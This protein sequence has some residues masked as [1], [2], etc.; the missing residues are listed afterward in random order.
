MIETDRLVL[1]RWRDA[2]TAPFFAMGQDAEVMRHIGPPMTYEDAA[3]TVARV[4]AQIDSDGHA[5]WAVECRAD[6]AFIGFCGV[7]HGP[8]GTPIADLPEIGWRLA[9]TAWGQGYAREAAAASLGWFWAN[10][11]A[12]RVFAITTPANARSWGLMIRLGMARVT[13]GD[14]DHPALAEADPLR[15]HLTYAIDRPAR[16]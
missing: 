6:A 5:F 14:F 10:T 7:K 16:D 11:I 8:P 2:D 1:R 4:N 13:D 3:R 15:R 9:R 12:P